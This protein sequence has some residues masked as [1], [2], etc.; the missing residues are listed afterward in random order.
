MADMM[1][2]AGIDAAGDVDL[3]R[4]DLMLPLEIGEPSRDRLRDRDRAGGGQRAI[5]EAGAGDDVAGKPDIGGGETVRP[6]APSR[7]VEIVALHMRQHE[8]LVMAHPQLV[9][10]VALGKIGD[11]AHLVGGGIAGDAALPAS[12][13]Y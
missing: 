12:A 6:P 2:A 4:A 11:R 8:I 9:E 10:A 1:M 7:R 3:E 13:R 5:V